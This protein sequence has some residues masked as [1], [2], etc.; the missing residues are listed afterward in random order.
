MQDGHLGFLLQ[1]NSNSTEKNDQSDVH[2]I[3]L[4]H[5]IKS[6]SAPIYHMKL[7]LW[8][9][10]L[11][12][13]L[14][15]IIIQLICYCTKSVVYITACMSTQ[16]PLWLIYHQSKML[17]CHWLE[18]GH[19]T[20]NGNTYG[21]LSVLV[22]QWEIDSVTVELALTFLVTTWNE[23]Q[24]DLAKGNIRR[25]IMW[26]AEEIWQARV[27]RWL[28]KAP[29]SYTGEQSVAIQLPV[30]GLMEYNW[31]NTDRR[32]SEHQVSCRQR[33]Q[34]FRVLLCRQ[35]QIHLDRLVPS[36]SVHCV[37]FSPFLPDNRQLASCLSNSSLNRS[38]YNDTVKPNQQQVQTCYVTWMCGLMNGLYHSYITV[39]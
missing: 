15:I 39:D 24:S 28:L 6:D 2:I 32:V 11:T 37:I 34:I 10:E 35:H 25:L 9:V 23:G 12:K 26:Y 27:R 1:F 16:K 20:G 18:A 14:C 21:I 13:I 22:N 17:N 5:S 19:V 33:C 38:N 29:V 36:L 7:S 8:K 31:L 30:K 4:Y 3:H